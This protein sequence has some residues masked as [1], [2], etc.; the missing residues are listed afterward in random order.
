MEN[1]LNEPGTLFKKPNNQQM[2][3]RRI[4]TA[5]HICRNKYE[6]QYYSFICDHK[7]NRYYK[8][9]NEIL[10]E[11]EMEKKYPIQIDA[12]SKVNCDTRHDWMK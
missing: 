3:D 10:T 5:T 11:C 9:G 12:K 4:H 1:Y 6:R 8:K 7:G 2:I